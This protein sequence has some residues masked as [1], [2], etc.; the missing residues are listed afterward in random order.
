MIRIF[1][2]ALIGSIAFNTH[3]Q[4]LDKKITKIIEATFDSRS[5]LGYRFITR[6]NQSP[7]LFSQIDRDVLQ[8]YNFSDDSLVGASFRITYGTARFYSERGD[9]EDRALLKEELIILELE[10]ID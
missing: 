7:V 10:E 3:A 9:T 6:M 1:L 4:E 2:F 8:D 5:E